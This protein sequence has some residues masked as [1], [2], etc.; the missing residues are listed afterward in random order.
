[1]EKRIKSTDEDFERTSPPA[2]LLEN[3][4]NQLIALTYD[5]VE[6]RIK[7]GT[8]N[9]H[10]YVHFLRMG[11]AKAQLE[12]KKLEAETH[13]LESKKEMIESTKQNG[14]KYQE[15]IDAFREYSGQA[16]E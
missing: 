14:V 2:R 9:G 4:E 1:M 6:E 15:A 5:K 12:K 11:A 16:N 10:E 8:A 3:R 13:L 7:N